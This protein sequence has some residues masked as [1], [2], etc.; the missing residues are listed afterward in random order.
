MIN[1]IIYLK[2]E[3]NPHELVKFL[4]E[5][6]LIASASIDMENKSYVMEDGL[7]I[8]EVHNVITAHTKALL[9]VN[10][11]EA[12]EGKIGESITI[13]SVPIVGTSSIFNETVKSKTIRV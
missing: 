5:E 12:S 1:V 10:I 6:K 7:L 9:L 3:H 4:L 8:E 2:K 13:N 11:I